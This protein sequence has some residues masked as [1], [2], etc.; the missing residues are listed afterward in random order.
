VLPITEIWNVAAR[1]VLGVLRC[2]AGMVSDHRTSGAFKELR[3]L[4]SDAVRFVGVEPIRRCQRQP[5]SFSDDLLKTQAGICKKK[6]PCGE[7]D[8]VKGDFRDVFGE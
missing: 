1:R 4:L 2:I 8:L 7:M 3:N 6:P 5:D